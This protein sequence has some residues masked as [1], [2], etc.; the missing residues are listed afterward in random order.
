M[1]GN[2][3]LLNKRNC[4]EESGQFFIFGYIYLSD[5][6]DFMI[7]IITMKEECMYLKKFVESI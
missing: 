5:A 6:Y 4:P 2:G 7:Q 3:K 1:D